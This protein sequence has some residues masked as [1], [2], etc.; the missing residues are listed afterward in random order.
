[1]RSSRA[2]KWSEGGIYIYIYI[3]EQKW[4]KLTYSKLVESSIFPLKVIFLALPLCMTVLESMR[5]SATYIW[6]RIHCDS[7]SY[8]FKLLGKLIVQEQWPIDLFG[9]ENKIL[10]RNPYLAL[11]WVHFFMQI[12]NYNQ[13]KRNKIW[14]AM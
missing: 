2:R 10:K 13:T 8:K 6:A 4:I 1:M 9:G 12:I 5:E 14:K 11:S 7:K 3:R